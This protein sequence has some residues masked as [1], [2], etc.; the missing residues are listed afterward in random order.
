[1]AGSVQFL[2]AHNISQL[3]L[4]PEGVTQPTADRAL[5]LR[6]RIAVT[7]HKYRVC[8]KNVNKRSKD[9]NQH[10]LYLKIQL[11]PRSKHT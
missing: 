4:N 9:E 10:G 5:N 2:S 7:S 8:V 6:S 1:M 3:F 11:V